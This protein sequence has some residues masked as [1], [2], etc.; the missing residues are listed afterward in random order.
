MS[1][2]QVVESPQNMLEIGMFGGMYFRRFQCF[3]GQG[4]VGHLHTYHHPSMVMRGTFRYRLWFAE[5]DEIVVTVKAP[6]VIH[7]PAEAFHEMQCLTDV[8]E[9]WCARIEK[10]ADGEI[11]EYIGPRPRIPYWSS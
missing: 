5:N 4:I 8:G 7:V 3:K 10:D 9:V 2:L 6:G 1:L 11:R